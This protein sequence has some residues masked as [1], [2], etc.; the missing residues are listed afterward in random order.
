MA[1]TGAAASAESLQH[2]TA[3]LENL[4][5]R[6]RVYEHRP[7]M[8]VSTTAISESSELAAALGTD[9][10]SESSLIGSSVHTLDSVPEEGKGGVEEVSRKLSST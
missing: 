3:S 7:S 8:D 5:S 9:A 4:L 6:S 10:G 2:Q 1:S